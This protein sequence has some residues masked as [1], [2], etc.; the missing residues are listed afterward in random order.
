MRE[1]ARSVFQKIVDTY[2]DKENI[3]AVSHG[4]MLA[5]VI[6]VV[7]NERIA[8]FSDKISLDSGS[9]FRVCYID[10]VVGLTKY[11]INESGFTDICF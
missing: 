4:A 11:S 1:R 2:N 3:L 10:K 6:T 8:Y 7:T 5:A 9:L